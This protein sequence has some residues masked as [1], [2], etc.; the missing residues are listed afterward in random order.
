MTTLVER[1]IVYTVQARLVERVQS[2]Q[3]PIRVYNDYPMIAG[4][5]R[6]LSADLALVATPTD[7][8]LLAADFKYEPCH[9]RLDL[10]KNKL[11]VTVWT[12]VTHDI[13]RAQ[14]F[15]DQGRTKIAY[16][17]CIDEGNYLAKRDLSVYEDHLEW[18]G[19]PHHDHNIPV[20]MF[21]VPSRLVA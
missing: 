16:A 1:D 14:Q 13:D 9:R 8:V 21:R 7:Q 11:P 15:V 17:V 18:T 19:Q 12:E 5:R 10:L 2:K 6:S 4:T 3:W 20:H